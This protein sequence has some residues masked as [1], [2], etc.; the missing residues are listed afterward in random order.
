MKLLTFVLLLTV[1]SSSFS[2]WLD[3]EG[4]VVQI[5]TYADKN[6]ILV[7][8]TNHG[9][10]VTACSSKSIFAISS[11]ISEES[12]ARMFSMLL[13]AQA[14]GREVV[15]SYNDVGGCE[16]WGASENVYRKIVRL[17]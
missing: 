13:A 14:S 2:A 11:A 15:V 9:T 8:L 10:D 1:S 16:P 5:A 7:T 17:K 12:R 6:T 3:T 4:H